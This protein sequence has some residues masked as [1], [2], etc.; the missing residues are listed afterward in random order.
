LKDSE[1]NVSHLLNAKSTSNFDWSDLKID[2]TQFFVKTPN[3]SDTNSSPFEDHEITARST[4]IRSKAL[5]FDELM[6]SS[7]SAAVQNKYR[8]SM[9]QGRL[10]VAQGAASDFNDTARKEFSLLVKNNPFD[11]NFTRTNNL[12][13]SNEDFQPAE[14]ISSFLNEDMRKN[15]MEYAD[16]PHVEGITYTNESNWEDNLTLSKQREMSFGQYCNK[17][18]NQFNIR[19]IYGGKSPPKRQNR[20]PL[21][22]VSTNDTNIKKSDSQNLEEL[23][24]K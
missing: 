23:I 24:R 16:I 4:A 18:V 15:E 7:M 13:Y 21:I 6:K 17:N 12:T 19:D 3:R 5:D 11:G 1:P 22:D 9:A 14:E 20:V 10:S 8:E 2:K